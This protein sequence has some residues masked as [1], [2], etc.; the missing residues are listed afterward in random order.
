MAEPGVSPQATLLPVTGY[1][2]FRLYYDVPVWGGWRELR[3][4]L[5]ERRYWSNVNSMLMTWSLVELLRLNGL[6]EFLLLGSWQLLTVVP[7][8]MEEY[9][10]PYFHLPVW[11]TPELVGDPLMELKPGDIV[12]SINMPKKGICE[13]LLPDKENIV[14]SGYTKYRWPPQDGSR[15]LQHLPARMRNEDFAGMEAVVAPTWIV[16]PAPPNRVG[17]NSSALCVTMTRDPR[18]AVIGWLQPDAQVRLHLIEGTRALLGYLEE[19]NAHLAGGWISVVRLDGCATLRRILEETENQRIQRELNQHLK[20]LEAEG[21]D[22]LEALKMLDE[23]QDVLLCESSSA[24]SKHSSARISSKLGSKLSSRM[25]SKIGSRRSSADRRTSRSTSQHHTPR[26][27]RTLAWP[28]VADQ[29]VGPPEKQEQRETVIGGWRQITDPIWGRPLYVSPVQ[30]RS[31]WGVNEVIKT[32]GLD[33]LLLNRSWELCCIDPEALEIQK[34]EDWFLNVYATPSLTGEAIAHWE[35][36]RMIIVQMFDAKTGVATVLIPPMEIEGDAATGYVSYAMRDGR[37]LLKAMVAPIEEWPE[38]PEGQLYAGAKPPEGEFLE[39]PFFNVLPLKQAELIVT[40]GQDVGSDQWAKMPRGY[41]LRHF[42][43]I[44]GF[45]ARLPDLEGGGWVSLCNAKGMPHFRKQPS[46]APELD[47]PDELSSRGSKSSKLSS[48]H[49]VHRRKGHFPVVW[50]GLGIWIPDVPPVPVP[51]PEPKSLPELLYAMGTGRALC[52]WQRMALEPYKEMVW[53]NRHAPSTTRL[54]D[55]L[56]LRIWKPA[57]VET[58]WLHLREAEDERSRRIAS[59]PQ[60]SLVVTQWVT[61]TGSVRLL[62]PEEEDDP[63]PGIAWADLGGAEGACVVLLEE[64][65]DFWVEPRGGHVADEDQEDSDQFRPT[66]LSVRE[67]WESDSPHVGSLQRGDVVQLAEISGRFGRVVRIKS[68]EDSDEA[69]GGWLDLYTEAGW[70]CL[71]KRFPGQVHPEEVKR[72]ILKDSVESVLLQLSQEVEQTGSKKEEEIFEEE[73]AELPELLRELGE[74]EAKSLYTRDWREAI[75]PIWGRRYFINRWSGQVIHKLTRYG[76]AEA[77]VRLTVYFNNLSVNAA[78]LHREEWPDK[79]LK[80]LEDSAIPGFAAMADVPDQRVAVKFLAGPE[81]P[82]EN[83]EPPTPNDS[84]DSITGEATYRPARSDLKVEV[85]LKAPGVKAAWASAALQRLMADAEI[86]SNHIAEVLGSV[87]QI[88]LLQ[89]KDGEPFTM[90]RADLEEMDIARE[91]DLAERARSK[92]SEIEELAALVDTEF[93]ELRKNLMWSRPKSMQY[94]FHQIGEVNAR[95]MCEGLEMAY[96]ADHAQKDPS[97]LEEISIWG[98]SIGNGGAVALANALAIGCG[99]KLQSIILDE[100]DIGAAGAKALGVGL[101]SCPFLREL[102]LPKNPLGKGFTSLL[103]GLGPNLKVLDAAEANLDDEAALATS[104]TITR[105][106]FLRSLRL[107][108]NAMT[109]LGIDALVRSM[110]LAKDLQQL[111][112]RGSSTTPLAVE[113]HRLMKLLQKGNIDTRKLRL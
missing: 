18:S 64:G 62:F 93:V 77:V 71:R 107:A 94:A 98:C 31:T 14:K 21:I 78:G 104:K 112:L 44:L 19:E 33:D 72:R 103:S 105:W 55:L 83:S 13:I 9:E 82:I 65:L 37:P 29:F 87:P 74:L 36:G 46:E 42:A 91:S 54:H 84:E 49:G 60:G 108:G 24:S 89:L 52:D 40:I 50:P 3:D 113:W 30:G 59:M 43:E 15:Y 39:G 53:K 109:I 8:K 100:N 92:A 2:P 73:E 58:E 81:D 1:D 11:P 85:M 32:G 48:A 111:D 25:G 51:K 96:N 38:L 12:A 68:I 97:H 7:E 56:R 27:P 10:D 106:P 110:L 22:T 80:Q 28:K 45:R 67:T 23:A 61:S 41:R 35:K 34:A 79:K 47:L 101:Q 5:T 102:S 69:V 66:K 63:S 70:S 86:F 17:P 26:T 90:V 16:L 88:W 76:V 75:D 20:E 6:E 57:V 4:P 99:E 95:A